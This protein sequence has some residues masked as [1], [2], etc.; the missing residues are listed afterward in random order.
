MVIV[1][2]FPVIANMLVDFQ[3]TGKPNY[4]SECLS[5]NKTSLIVLA[6][7]INSLSNDNDLSKLSLKTYKR[8]LSAYDL[9]VSNAINKIY[10]SGGVGHDVKEANIMAELLIALGVDSSMLVI[11]N[12]S[13]STLDNAVN[14]SRLISN[15][16]SSSKYILLTSA[17]HMKRASHSFRSV[18]IEICEYAVDSIYIN[19]H[20]WIP[21]ITALHKSTIA[22]REIF[23]Y[24]SYLI[25][26]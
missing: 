26:R 12:N 7:G 25:T 23:I 16:D 5:D 19:S 6:G 22:L 2:S 11:E 3:E 14:V 8:T 4:I 20:S 17:L 13:L 21:Q 9:Y 18:G 15:D 24:W 1:L 10:L